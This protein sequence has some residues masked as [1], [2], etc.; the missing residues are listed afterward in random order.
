MKPVDV[1]AEHVKN[2][3]DVDAVAVVDGSADALIAGLVEAG[4]TLHDRVDHIAGK[5][6]RVVSPPQETP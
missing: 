6:I 2:C 4:W 1:L 5:R 3:M